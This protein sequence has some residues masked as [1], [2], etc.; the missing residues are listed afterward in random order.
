MRKLLLPFIAIALGSGTLLSSCDKSTEGLSD[1]T[2]GKDFMPLEI[3]RY[4]LYDVDSIYWDDF[5]RAEIHK[6]SQHR[7]DVV[8]TFRDN[9][10]RLSYVI[11]VLSRPSA[12]FPFT[13]DNVIHVTPTEKT[14]EYYQHNLT[15][16]KLTFPV[17]DGMSWNG[18]S[19]I[20]VGDADNVQF[21]NDNWNYTYSKVGESFDP[22]NNFY[23]SSVTVDEI[24]DQLNDPAVDSTA[25]SYKNYSQEV[26]AY[27]VGLVYRHRIYWVFQ[28]S[29]GS[30]GGGS[31]Y[32]KG[33]AVTMRAVDNN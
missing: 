19:M 2:G 31:G 7:Y 27:G 21:D 12:Q 25:Y 30:A 9:A 6:R 29:E 5:L 26:Y 17:D 28:P 14:I 8:D 22:G 24:D 13:P 15:F 16:I 33:Y 32:K 3:G 18:N 1:T 10:N 4:I 20:P 23:A 11:N